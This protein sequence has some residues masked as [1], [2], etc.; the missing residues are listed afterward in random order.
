MANFNH[1][2]AITFMPGPSYEP[3]TTLLGSDL[4]PAVHPNT[5]GQIRVSNTTLTTASRRENNATA[6]S[7]QDEE[8][9]VL[10]YNYNPSER[11]EKM[12][13]INPAWR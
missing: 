5:T 8:E 7:R 9:H 11:I 2:N 1:G 10:G 3:L 12:F 13:G 4:A 6:G